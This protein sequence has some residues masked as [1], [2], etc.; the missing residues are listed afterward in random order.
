MGQRVPG[1]RR[2]GR[3]VA[4]RQP[5]RRPAVPGRARHSRHRSGPD[6][7]PDP[8]RPARPH[9]G[10]AAVGQRQPP[11][12]RP[13]GP[14][15]RQRRPVSGPDLRPLHVLDDLRRQRPPAGANDPHALPPR[16]APGPPRA[17]LGHDGLGH[18]RLVPHRAR[19]GRWPSASTGCRPA[20]PWSGPRWPSP[21][22]TSRTGSAS[23]W[24]STA[25][26]STTAAGGSGA[27]AG[28]ICSE[29]SPA[30]SPAAGAVPPSSWSPPASGRSSPRPGPSTTSSTSAT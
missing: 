15:L 23:S 21:T 22:G 8:G 14:R 19:A 27:R 13:V 10:P 2:G 30:T 26:T 20:R 7:R 24:G 4:D 18:R 25:A 6:R 16:R 12:L 17:V 1:W 9:P 5:G 3:G 29:A 28:T 11:V